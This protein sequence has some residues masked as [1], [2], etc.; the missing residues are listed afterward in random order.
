MYESPELNSRS[1]LK[2]VQTAVVIVA[3]GRGQRASGSGMPKQ[4]RPLAGTPI[5]TRA[6]E[7]FVSHGDVDA[8][9]TVIHGDDRSHFETAAAPFTGKLLEPVMGGAMRQ[10]SVRAG[11]ERLEE[12]HPR[13]VLIH[14][15]ARPFTDAGLIKRV[16]G[17]LSDNEGVVPA[18]AVTDTLKRAN[19]GLI[20]DT[21]D[22]AN[23]W[24]VQTPQGFHFEKLLEAHRAAERAGKT[25]FTDD[26]SLAEWHGMNV[27][28][29]EGSPANVKLTTEADFV[30]A[31]E[32]LAR[33]GDAH[34]GESRIGQGFDVHAFT[35][36]DHVTLCGLKI[37]YE[38]SLAGHSDADV[39]LHAL[40]DALLGAIADGDIGAHFPPSD[41]E[42]RGAASDQ[43]LRDAA[44][45]ISARGGRIINLDVT[46]I[47]EAPKIGPHR[48]NMRLRIAEILRIEPERVSVKATTT[49]G[50][51]FTGRGEG[52]AAQATAMIQLG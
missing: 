35:D 9:L 37:P 31:G 16:I 24:G 29:V 20:E 12:L 39:G 25:D 11:L 40:T 14:D 15:A 52:I 21:V 6:L 19:E 32:R 34:S 48:E 36:G 28:L 17:A 10:D 22:R 51:G 42:W 2:T 1:I 46:I 49:E 18:L 30:L 38:R 45:R 33:S 13:N 41:P 4:Y 23:L 27:A 8:I 44:D 3:G 43:F 7:S 5:L 26:S 47:C 50:L